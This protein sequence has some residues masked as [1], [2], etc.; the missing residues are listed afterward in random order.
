MPEGAGQTKEKRC[1]SDGEV[2][3]TEVIEDV[4]GELGESGVWI[5]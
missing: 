4:E 2:R 3:D 1:I 5:S